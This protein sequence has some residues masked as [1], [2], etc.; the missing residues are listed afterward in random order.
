MTSLPHG[1]Q[2]IFCPFSSFA[3]DTPV[4]KHSREKERSGYPP[5]DPCPTGPIFSS[6]DCAQAGTTDQKDDCNRRVPLR[7]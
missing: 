7:Y 1:T 6:R 5:Q 3:I 4:F 2:T